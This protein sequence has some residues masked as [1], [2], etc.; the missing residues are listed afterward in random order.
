MSKRDQILSYIQ[1][2]VMVCLMVCNGEIA[3][4]N[5]RK[6]DSFPVRDINAAAS[7]N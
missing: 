1:I 3:V 7:L 5:S 6:S 4:N 2:L